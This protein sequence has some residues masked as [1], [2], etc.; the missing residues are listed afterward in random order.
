MMW[1]SK[2]AVAAAP[3]IEVAALSPDLVSSDRLNRLYRFWKELRGSRRLPCRSDFAPEQLS[4]LLGQITVVDVL[5][6]PANFRYRLIGT[7]LE[8]A[9]R[10]GDQGKTLDQIEPATYRTMVWRNF[11]EVVETG[12]PLC[13]QVSYA[14]HHNMASFEQLILPFS[15]AGTTV[16]VLL[17]ALDWMPGV[18]HDFK[19]VA[20]GRFPVAVPPAH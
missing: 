4:F 17:E 20:S 5:R 10:R 7:R 15:R 14:H 2:S 3:E 19:S 16:E 9:G 8:E 1:L 12:Q 18:Q 11:R 13:H 6:D